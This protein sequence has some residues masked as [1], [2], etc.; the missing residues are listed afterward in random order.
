MAGRQG[1]DRASCCV[2]RLSVQAGG[3]A[4]KLGNL[5]ERLYVLDPQ[6]LGSAK[7]VYYLLFCHSFKLNRKDLVSHSSQSLDFLSDY[8]VI[9]I[10]V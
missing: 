8:F 4:Q 9:F 3:D 5:G 2:W 1:G 7:L 6:F 10:I